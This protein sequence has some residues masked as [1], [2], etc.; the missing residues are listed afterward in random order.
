MDWG[1]VCLSKRK[2]GLGI[3]RILDKNSGLLAKWVWRFRREDKS[4]WKKI[5]CAKY[6]FNAYSLTC[7]RNHPD[8]ASN[9]VKPISSLFSKALSPLKSMIMD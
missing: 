2:G 6:G 7:R 4:L 9:F 5:L 3:G 1:I 8:K